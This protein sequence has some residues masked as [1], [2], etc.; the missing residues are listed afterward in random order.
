MNYV[1]KN[2]MKVIFCRNQAMTVLLSMI[3]S[4]KGFHI[5]KYY[6]IYIIKAVNT[7]TLTLTWIRKGW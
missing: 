4:T 2:E 6:P 5:T 3:Y 7:A 1:C